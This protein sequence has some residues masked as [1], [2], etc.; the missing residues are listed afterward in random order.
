M[1]WRQWLNESS[2]DHCGHLFNHT[3]CVTY[4]NKFED[5]VMVMASEV[6]VFDVEPEDVIQKDRLRPGKMLLVDT[7]KKSIIMDDE[8][9]RSIA[10]K[11]PHG[12]WWEEHVSLEDLRA[13]NKVSISIQRHPI[14]AETEDGAVQQD[15]KTGEAKGNIIDR[16]W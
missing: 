7:Q 11:R 15:T 4:L 8:V 16:L 10:R 5:N 14:F 9:K 2:S 13:A 6:G 3:A 12:D 1:G